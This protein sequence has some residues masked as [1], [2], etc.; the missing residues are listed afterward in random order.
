MSSSRIKRIRILLTLAAIV[1]L[2][3][4]TFVAIKFAQGYRPSFDSK[5]ISL[6]GNGL[7]SVASY[8]KSAQVYINDHLTTV[9]D[10][11]LYLLPGNYQIKFVKAGFQPWSKSLPVKAELVSL[12]DARLF[13]TIPSLTPLTFY[14]VENP[15]ISP[16]GNKLAYVL[17]GSPFNQDN[18]LY[19]LTLPN[20]LIG[21]QITQIADQ[22]R[23]DYSKASLLWSPDSSQILAV[24]S[25]NNRI[26]SSHLLG[27]RNLNQEKN[28]TDSTTKLPQILNQWQD[29]IMKV[30]QS[31]IEKIPDFMVKVASQS[32]VNV[33][34]SPD[35]EKFLYTPTTAINLPE[36]TIGKSLPNMNST[37]ETRSLVIGKTYVYD[38]KEGT[39]YQID[40]AIYN[41][42][43]A[44]PFIVTTNQVNTK[45]TKTD[46]L[47]KQLH[48]LKA[49]TEP[50]ST[51]NLNWY[52][53]SRHLMVSN[54]NGISIVEY[55]GNNNIP[56]TSAGLFHGFAVSS[57]DGN[58][59]VI[60]SNFNQ[61]PDIYNLFSLDLK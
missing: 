21:N 46:P 49:Q 4:G 56:I 11:T 34:F 5:N 3:T 55:D 16:D 40:S 14:K 20:M 9:T 12:T 15:T 44:E 29:Q 48:F 17:T 42:D 26:S 37:K 60:L 50:N 28:L 13:P 33:Y 7:L 43:Q 1:V 38:I 23:R 41:P 57:S 35:H 22:G 10:S 30:N 32:A 25:E 54:D 47:L 53:T 51:Q 2:S 36:N 61:K 52:S 58:R 59:L 6:S 45:P 27:T 18:G 19:I 8:P 39:N 31:L 24:F